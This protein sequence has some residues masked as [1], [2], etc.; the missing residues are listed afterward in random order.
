MAPRLKSLELHG[1]KTFASRTSFEYPGLITAIVGPNGSGK[2][3]I[4]DA[5]RWVL[6]EQ[7]Y[8]LLRGRKT[9]DMIFAGSEQRPRAGMASASIL[10]DNSDGWLPIDFGE[11]SITRRAYR[12]GTNEYLLN[13]QR[14]RLKEIGELLAQSGLAER[15]YTIIGQG[16]VDAALSLKPEERRKFFEEAAGIGLYRSRR[17]ES[18]NRL[19]TTRRNLERVQ[20]ILSELGPRL[21]SLEKQA[22]K[23]Q[24]YERIKAELRLLLRDWYGYH[25]HRTQ[26][27]W[28]HAHEVSK[29]QEVRQQHAREALEGVEKELNEL[30]NQLMELRGRLNGWHSQSADLHN[31]REKISR[32]LAVLNERQRALQDQ[33]QSLERDLYQYKEDEAQRQER[34][35]SLED[36]RRQL[37]EE[38]AELQN[39]LNSARQELDLQARKR[40][41]AE[42]SLHEARQKLISSQTWQVQVKAHQN[43]I[44]QRLETTR[45]NQK[46]AAQAI[47]NDQINL[48]KAEIQFKNAS[49]QRA[50]A[51][52][53]LHQL[54]AERS[55]L[56]S[57]IEDLDGLRKGNLDQRSSLEAERSRTKAQLDVLAQAERSFSGLNQ[58]SRFLLEASREGRVGKSYRALSQVLE[59]PAEIETAMAAV[60][61]E[62]LDGILYDNR[63]DLDPV[64]GLLET[65]SKG[66]AVLVPLQMDGEENGAIQ[67]ENESDCL[68]FAADL[69]KAPVELVPLMKALLGNVLVVRDRRTARRMM[70][71][72]PRSGRIVTLKGEVFWGSGVVVAGQEGRSGLISRPRQKRELAEALQNLDEKVDRTIQKLKELDEEL[73]TRRAALQQLE[74]DVKSANQALSAAGQAYQQASLAMEQ[75]RSQLEWQRKQA[76]AFD[77]QIKQSGQELARLGEEIKSLDGQIAGMS[78]DIHKRSQELAALPLDELQK[79]VVHWETSIAVT[80]RA[81]KESD[82]RINEQNQELAAQS[83]LIEAVKVRQASLASSQAELLGIKQQ[84][85]DQETDLNGEIENL[86]VKIT[87]AE[88]ELEGLEKQYSAL[89]GNQLSAQQAA[90]LADRLANQAQLEV[91]R[92]R[93]ALDALQRR[94]EEDFGL[95]AFE[96]EAEVS[97]PTPLPLEGMVEQL[98]RLV[99]LPPDLE[100]SINRQRAQLRRMGAVNPEA[101]KEY[102][103]VKERYEFLSAQTEDLR[104]ADVDLRQVITELDELMK[105]E[106]RKTFDAVAAEFKGLFTRLFGGGSARLVL[107]DEINPNEGGV[108]IEARLPGRREH[109]LSLLS[110]GER[111]L[112]AVALVFSLLKVSP[113]PFCVLDE[114]DAMLDEANVGRFRDLLVELSQNTQFI[115][116][117]HNRNT[118][119]AADVIY[120]V[121]MGR[122][123]ASQIISLK[124]DEV[125]E[126][127][128]K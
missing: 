18:L 121:T 125:S 43:E 47:E 5:L 62:F 98:P 42:N 48:T 106:F 64:L 83:K 51:Q 122:D 128:V 11:V 117:T 119:Q 54:E 102:R 14:V 56:R 60:L 46:A 107:M 55:G 88:G 33:A 124:L 100:P 24:E 23:A 97:G 25:W 108:D 112:T 9:E 78:D 74:R 93:E 37:G 73:S 16:L 22:R 77:G 103:E 15:T 82:R 81:V 58:G 28:S 59:V 8:S 127:L 31:R 30:R 39:Q 36:E 13:G 35:K 6:G 38:L 91:A 92:L 111:S 53:R 68:G 21:V 34:I 85:R 116:I 94:V 90:S 61:G 75:A 44:R 123:S 29:A 10:F 118:V 99:E 4:A 70:K 101:Q 126:E 27:D 40:Q 69:I 110:G 71:A 72:M 67:F 17:E 96:Y 86:Q 76:S 104:R 105:R 120:G 32:D 7:S 87:P 66:R 50:E 63:E 41:Q 1:Y 109:G 12:D 113:T 80:N 65:G 114:V 45:E 26:Q 84:L 57:K 52:D 19:E 115:I 3:N 95:V 79:Q 20:D 49:Q 2:S 89:Q